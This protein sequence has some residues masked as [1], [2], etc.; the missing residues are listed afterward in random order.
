MLA[1]EPTHKEAIELLADVYQ[2]TGNEE[3]LTELLIR[4]I[5]A[6][7]ARNDVP[8]VVALSLRLGKRLL[9]AAAPRA[10]PA[11]ST[12]GRWRW[13]PTTSA[14]CGRWRACCRPRRT[15]ASGRPCWS[16]CWTTRSG[17]EAGRLAIELG[18]LF[19]ALGDDE[20]VRR[21]LEAGV[22]RS[23]GDQAVFERLGEFYRIRHAWDRLA[24]LMIGRGGSPAGT[25]AR[26][27]RC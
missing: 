26:R 18:E 19:E 16:A 14:C 25:T 21:V 6:A 9:A 5:D 11:T 15:R 8:T 10:R 23:G 13:R 22:A 20:R 3:G 12:G 24:S 2:A 7:R 27:R 17:A 4:E 1:D